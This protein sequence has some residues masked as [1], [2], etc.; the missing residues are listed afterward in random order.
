VRRRAPILVITALA[1][2]GC[3]DDDAA[4]PTTT[5]PPV[6][7]D[8]TDA[9]LDPVWT[10][11][12]IFA[13]AQVGPE[14]DEVGAAVLI[15]PDTGEVTS[16]PAPPFDPL[17]GTAEIAA[18]GDAVFL[19]GSQCAER[20]SGEDSAFCVP[21]DVVGAVWSGGEWHEAEIP[22]E[23]QAYAGTVEGERGRLMP[24]TRLVG[25]TSDGRLVFDIIPESYREVGDAPYWTYS[26]GG[27]EW[28]RLGDPGVVAEDA[29]LAGDRLVMATAV[30]TSTGIADVSL[31]TL[32][33]ADPTA[34]WVAGPPAP[35]LR[36]GLGPDVHC[37]DDF[38]VVVGL[39]ELTPETSI[40]QGFVAQRQAVGDV[41][42]APWEPLPELPEDYIGHGRAQWDGQ[43]LVVVDGRSGQG[44]RLAADG[45]AWE[46]VA[47][48]RA[49]E[50]L[51]RV[52]NGEEFVVIPA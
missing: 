1:I 46:P 36:L 43:G 8:L 12:G 51:G 13:Y 15:D 20:I 30:E 42:S 34:V 28:V 14:D 4:T 40:D 25:V 31:R 35:G 11:D 3:A 29:C 21:G 18:A 41:R 52:W 6:E 47:Y 22:D 23:I 2:A 32:D 39:E 26:P 33:L 27:D 38:A 16:L 50:G 7:V 10:D 5:L 17:G 44:L 48:P 19:L 45:T 24:V 49:G 37:G 9:S